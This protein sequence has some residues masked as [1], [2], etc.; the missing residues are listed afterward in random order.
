MNKLGEYIME[1][2]IIKKHNFENSINE[3]KNFSEQTITDLDL[4]KVNNQDFIGIP[5]GPGFG[6]DHKVSGWE[7]NELT[8]QV[9][10]C[11]MN[12]TQIK[13]IKEFGQVY[14]A[15]DALDKDYIQAIL[16]SIKAIEETSKSLL[17]TQNQIKQVV[18]NQRKTIEE[19]IKFK[20]QMAGFSENQ[21]GS[22]NKQP[23][24]LINKMRL[25]YVILGGTATL[26]I[27]ELVLIIT[28]LI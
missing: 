1:E 17:E 23:N 25:I 14:S 24:S 9:Q 7:L 22:L 8:S 6:M 11:S 20:N 21:K 2:L 15:L 13:L 19:L 16:A 12:N 10:K 3:I 18:D 26:S 28:K 27:I 4:K 5:G